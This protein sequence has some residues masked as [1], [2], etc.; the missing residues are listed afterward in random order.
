MHEKSTSFMQSSSVLYQK[1][2]TEYKCPGDKN[3]LITI[4]EN[5][6]LSRSLPGRKNA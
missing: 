2:D 5:F 3:W 4:L 1:Y 6:L